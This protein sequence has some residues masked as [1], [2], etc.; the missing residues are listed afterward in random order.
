MN[1][2]DNFKAATVH[3][4]HFTTLQLQELISSDSCHMFKHH[5]HKD[6][7]LPL[8]LGH[9]ILPNTNPPLAKAFE[10]PHPPPS[11]LLFLSC[12]CYCMAIS[13]PLA[14]LTPPS[15]LS[16]PLTSNQHLRRIRATPL[17]RLASST[18]LP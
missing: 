13:L 5:F 1:F 2:R 16:P 14:P 7:V 18:G 15:L 12:P 8:C 11:L 6:N 4:Y 9:I 10:H 17:P 3:F